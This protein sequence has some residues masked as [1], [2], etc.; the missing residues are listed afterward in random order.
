VGWARLDD[1]LDDHPKILALLDEDGGAT[2]VGLWILCL[3]WAHRNTR[4]RDQVHGKLPSGLPRRYLG[5]SARDAAML[6]VKVKLWDETDDGGW[7]IHD[8]DAYLPTGEVR[9]K[10]SEAGKRGAEKRWAGHV[11]KQE[12]TNKTD[13]VDGKLPLPDGNLP[14]VCHD[15]AIG[16]PEP[17]Y[18]ADGKPMAN[19]GSRAPARR[20]SPTEMPSHSHTQKTSPIGDPRHDVEQ[21]CRHL[22]DRVEGNGSKRPTINKGWRDAARL[23]I[24]RDKHTVDQIMRAIDW[25]QGN[26][27]W[28]GNILSMP[29]LR[30]KYDQLRLAAEAERGSRSTP[31]SSTAPVAVPLDEQCPQHRGRRKGKCGLCRADALAKGLPY[32]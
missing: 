4:R 28:R 12:Q 25:C 17:C 16:L 10:R 15:V 26:E 6:L 5:P 14:S 8:F 13:S 27:F 18:D 11:R 29:K 22:A 19:D 1:G 9:D 23:M 30:D 32:P 2:A 24:D 31:A 7:V 3:T 21:V 20:A